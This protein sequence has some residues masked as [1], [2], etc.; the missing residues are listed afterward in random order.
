MPAQA[1]QS[2]LYGLLAEFTDADELVAAARHA[3]EAGYRRMEAY[4]PI[5]VHG[6]TEALGQ[7]PTRLPLI[8][9]IGGALGAISGYAMQYYAN[10]IDYPLNVG[11]RPYD[12]WPAYAPIIFELT[13]LG[14]ALSTVLGMLALNGLPMPYHPLFGVPGFERASRDRF[15]LCIQSRDE[16]FDPAATR[17]FLESL[18]PHSVQEAPR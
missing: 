11:G 7:T 14:A 12:S 10:V 13:V 15:F 6:L 2:D 3:R 8:T 4:S 9:F 17:A 5:P 1:D 16:L 18:A